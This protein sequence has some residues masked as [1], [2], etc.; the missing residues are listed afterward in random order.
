[1]VGPGDCTGLKEGKK[2]P[3]RGLSY[4]AP[5]SDSFVAPSFKEISC[6][7]LYDLSPSCSE[8]FLWRHLILKKQ[9]P[10]PF[11]RVIIRAAAIVFRFV[12]GKTLRSA[13]TK[14]TFT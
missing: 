9:H 8:N 12:I 10:S 11:V 6:P 7:G 1:V 4:R 5:D 13:F 2:T 3:E 14:R